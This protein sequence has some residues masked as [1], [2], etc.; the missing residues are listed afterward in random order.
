MFGRFC[1]ERRHKRSND[2]ADSA[3]RLTNAHS[4]I[5]AARR[6]TRRL[7]Q[8]PKGHAPCRNP[9]TDG[10]IPPG[11]E[12]IV[13]KC[14]EK[15]PGA[16]FQSA[17][18]LAFALEGASVSSGATESVRARILPKGRE[19]VAWLLAGVCALAWMVVAA[20]S[21]LFPSA[22]QV[23]SVVQAAIPL[24]APLQVDLQESSIALSPD[25]KRLVYRPRG[26]GPLYLRALDQREGMPLPGT[27]DGLTPFF[28]PDA[29]LSPDGRWVA[30]TSDESGRPGVVCGGPGSAG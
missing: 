6:A 27:D 28:P 3:N 7:R 4:T 18:D 25:G 26:S 5:A 1:K 11:L 2:E 24:N 17:G 13:G 9:T 29:T 21:A 20:R 15:N 14:L 22:A 12:R 8:A 10:R 30:Y 19:R 23:G 16:R